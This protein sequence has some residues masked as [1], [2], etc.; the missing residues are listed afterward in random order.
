MYTVMAVSVVGLEKNLPNR[1]VGDKKRIVKQTATRI[2]VR[3][4]KKLKKRM[5]VSGT[6]AT[7]LMIIR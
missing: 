2:L 6:L 3:I 5:I 7:R 1:E 4:V